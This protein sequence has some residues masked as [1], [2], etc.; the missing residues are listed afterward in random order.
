MTSIM[1]LQ[2]TEHRRRHTIADGAGPLYR[3]A[4]ADDLAAL[5]AERQSR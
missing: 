5:A 4:A 1:S 2:V 3:N